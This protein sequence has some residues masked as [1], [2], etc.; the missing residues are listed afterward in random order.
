MNNSKLSLAAMLLAASAALT[1]CAGTAPQQGV[2]PAS[3]PDSAAYGTIDSIQL[4]RVNPNASGT[5][6]I[7]GGVVGALLGN[8]I[9]SGTGRSAATLAGALG[10]ALAGNEIEKNRAQARDA[11]QISVR[12]DN[13][14]YRTVVQDSAAELRVGQRVRVVDGRV[15]RY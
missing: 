13:G 5:G 14:D 6:A 12:L 3:Q 2:Y 8:Q 7:A 1:G 4:T 9:G 15:Y 10:G 11:Y